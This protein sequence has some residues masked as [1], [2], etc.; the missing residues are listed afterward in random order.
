MALTRIQAIS[1]TDTTFASSVNVTFA[2]PNTAHNSILL[3]WE[4]DT[5]ALNSGN[6]PTDTAGNTYTRL[7][8]VSVAATFELEIWIAVDIKNKVGNVV[9]VTDTIGGSDGILI[10]EEWGGTSLLAVADGSSTNTGNTSPLTAGSFTPATDDVLI[11]VAGVESVGASDLT[12]AAGYSNL[13]QNATTFSNLGICSKV[14][15]AS[16]VQN[17]GF[18]SLVGVSWACAAVGIKLAPSR[19]TNYGNYI[20]TGNGMSR[21]E[22]AN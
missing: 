8:A 14:I 11:W 22:V 1:G 21:S 5:G 16:S 6:T 18:T 13:T 2:T 15:S 7:K 20:K 10:V 3:A 9:T 17:G 19:F 4:G 12:A